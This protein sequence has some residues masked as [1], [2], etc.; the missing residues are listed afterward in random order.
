[1]IVMKFGGTSVEDARSMKG[2]I[3]I[4]NRQLGRNRL[5]PLMNANF[6]ESN[7]IPVKASLAMMGLIQESYRL[8]MVPIGEKN[9]EKLKK[10]LAEL[11]LI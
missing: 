5:M 3:E 7:P 8:P 6:L 9:R 10:I 1:M 2:A 11:K 4:V